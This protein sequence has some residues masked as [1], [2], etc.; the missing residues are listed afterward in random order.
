MLSHGLFSLLTE[1]LMLHSNQF[2]MTTYNV[3]FEVSPLHTCTLQ[4]CAEF[5]VITSVFYCLPLFIL[6]QFN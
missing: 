1:R 4:A 3:L 5:T 2:T 6:L